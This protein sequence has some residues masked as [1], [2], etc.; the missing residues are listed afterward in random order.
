MGKLG[1]EWDKQWHGWD[2]RYGTY[3]LYV[4][5]V[6]SMN[7]TDENGTFHRPSHPS[8]SEMMQNQSILGLILVVPSSLFHVF[9]AALHRVSQFVAGLRPLASA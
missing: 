3:L 7:G 6:P 9:I 1:V 4:P 5:S 8:H 2:G